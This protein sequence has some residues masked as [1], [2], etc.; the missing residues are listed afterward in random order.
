MLRGPSIK[1]LGWIYHVSQSRG[2]IIGSGFPNTY[3]YK[4]I[5][6]SSPIYFVTK[7]SNTRYEKNSLPSIKWYIVSDGPA[8]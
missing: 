5:I 6:H 1:R 2:M 8:L 3:I 4:L 7:N